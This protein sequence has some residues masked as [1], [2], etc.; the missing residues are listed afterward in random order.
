MSGLKSDCAAD[1]IAF[2]FKRNDVGARG[3]CDNAKVTGPGAVHGKHK[4]TIGEARVLHS[5]R[6]RAAYAP[7]I[8][9]AI[10]ALYVRQ[11]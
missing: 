11:S 3:C 4:V 6:Q 2:D 10:A 5:L 9:F 7:R 1:A 8:S